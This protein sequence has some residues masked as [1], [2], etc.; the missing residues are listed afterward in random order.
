MTPRERGNAHVGRGEW[1]DAVRCYREA[2]AGNPGD[3]PSHVGLG[4]ASIQLGDRDSARRAL[5]RAIVLDDASFDAHYLLGCLA[6]DA[7]D[8]DAAITYFRDAIDRKPDFVEAHRDLIM[9]AIVHAP[10]SAK[11][12]AA[13]AVEAFPRSGEFWFYL[14]GASEASGDAEAALAGY[15]RVCS[16]EPKALEAQ[17]KAAQA[18]V[19]RKRFAEALTHGEAWASLAPDD[20]DAH[21]LV[22]AARIETGQIERGI[23]SYRRSL[24]LRPHAGIEHL[25]A[26]LTGKT[27]DRASDEYVAQLFDSYAD[28]FDTHLVGALKYSTPSQIMSLLDGAWDRRDAVVL[29]LGCGTGLMGVELEGRTAQMVGVDLSAKMLE[30]ARE[31]NLY[32]RLVQADL[33]EMM[34]K[35]P[36][37][38]FDL[39]VAADVFVYVGKLDALFEQTRRLLRPGGLFAFSVEAAVPGLHAQAGE[40]GYHLHERGRYVHTREYIERLGTSH[41]LALHEMRDAVCREDKGVPVRAYLVLFRHVT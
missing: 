17:K 7:G 37:C 2:I 32:A 36:D 12:A 22:G 10:A 8:K 25:I 24:A 30:K 15:R 28:D 38:S 23:E 27:P 9:L 6:R 11:I 4:F 34:H 5:E 20:P 13:R 40:T 26:S 41:G 18:L 1:N 29:D 31:R 33:V 16:L 19:S 14:A 21:M 35:E 39:V 3:A